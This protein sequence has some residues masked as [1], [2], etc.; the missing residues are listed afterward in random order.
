MLLVCGIIR[1]LE[2]ISSLS[3]SVIQITDV[4]QI[5]KFT[6]PIRVHL[7][8]IFLFVLFNPFGNQRPQ[9][10]GFD[11]PVRMISA[12]FRQKSLGHVRGT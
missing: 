3:R 7:R 4:D 11:F 6:P 12:K 8:D 10:F 2:K 1:N 9:F 5:D